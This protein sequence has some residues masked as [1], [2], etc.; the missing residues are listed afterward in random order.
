MN[1]II[2]LGIFA[3]VISDQLTKIW[4]VSHLEAGGDIAIWENVFHLQYIS[5]YG[6][7]WGIFSGKQF[8]LIGFTAI[9]IVGMMIYMFKMPKENQSHWM[10]VAF[11]L[12]M[13][14]AIGNLIDRIHLGY[15]RDFLY[16]KLIDF[17]IFNV[18]DI[19]VVTGVGLLLL[20]ILISDSE[21]K[22]EVEK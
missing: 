21:N 15:V 16:F 5:N 17:P 13:S 6:A 3:L 7:A 4:A 9:I 14:G 1:F 22:K 18:A 8:L 20:L 10:K 2:V 11:M 12:I 19:L